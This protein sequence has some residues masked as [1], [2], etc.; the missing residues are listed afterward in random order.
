MGFQA[1]TELRG[2][3]VAPSVLTS[4]KLELACESLPSPRGLGFPPRRVQVSSNKKPLQFYLNLSKRLL[5]EYG[6]VELSALGLGESA[7]AGGGG[8]GKAAWG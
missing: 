1:G 2:V 6:E 7:A 5:N 3:S 4:T 8:G